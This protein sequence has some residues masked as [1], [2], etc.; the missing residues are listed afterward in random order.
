MCCALVGCRC[1]ADPPEIGRGKWR[2][3][4]ACVCGGCW[5]CGSRVVSWRP[6]GARARRDA[7]I[8]DARRVR[9]CVRIGYFTCDAPTNAATAPPNSRP[10]VIT[11]R[12]APPWPSLHRPHSRPGPQTAEPRPERPRARRATESSGHYTIYRYTFFKAHTTHSSHAFDHRSRRHAHR[13]AHAGMARGTRQLYTQARA[14]V[15]TRAPTHATYGPVNS[16][17]DKYRASRSRAAGAPRAAYR[18]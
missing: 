9:A 11:S 15:A 12:G 6:A 2:R 14:E 3:G 7:L 18:L 16:T 5:G 10:H 1:R 8:T 4:A 17:R 13:H